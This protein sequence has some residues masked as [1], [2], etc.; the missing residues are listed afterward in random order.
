MLAPDCFP[1]P[2]L[3][4]RDSITLL[5]SVFNEFPFDPT[6]E[7]RILTPHCDEPSISNLDLD[8]RSGQHVVTFAIGGEL[9][10]DTMGSGSWLGDPDSSEGTELRGLACYGKP[11]EW[12][13][14]SVLCKA[15]RLRFSFQLDLDESSMAVVDDSGRLQPTTAL[16]CLS[17]VGSF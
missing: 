12:N 16:N 15:S 14:Y 5:V 6:V 7:V 2:L 17:L 4:N 13:I 8:V 9:F 10:L 3:N 1:L 11:Q